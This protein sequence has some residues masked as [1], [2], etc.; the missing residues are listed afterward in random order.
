MPKIQAIPLQPGFFVGDPQVPAEIIRI[1]SLALGGRQKPPFRRQPSFVAVQ[2]IPQG[3]TNRNCPINLSFRLPIFTIYC[4]CPYSDLSEAF[5]PVPPAN[6]KRTEPRTKHPKMALFSLADHY[7]HTQQPVIC[8][9]T[10][11]LS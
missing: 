8:P 10:V 1:V 3:R 9:K 4:F 6:L 7:N 5:G 2:I 11:I